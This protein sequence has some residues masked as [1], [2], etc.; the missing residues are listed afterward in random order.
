M[1]RRR[2]R[3][4]RQWSRAPRPRLV[5]PSPRGTLSPHPRGCCYL[6]SASAA[7]RPPA[8]SPPAAWPCL[9]AVSSS[10]A[11][12]PGALKRRGEGEDTQGTGSCARAEPTSADT[13]AWRPALKVTPY[14]LPPALS[15][16]RAVPAGDLD[17]PL[18]PGVAAGLSRSDD[19][20]LAP[21]EHRG[22]F[23]FQ[24]LQNGPSPDS[25]S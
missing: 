7:H 12:V 9:L 1:T 5:L 17:A 24:H 10:V 6:S 2:V 18:A 19:V 3:N 4:R 21:C 13:H 11:S 8:A 15:R 16:R 14:P 22:P 23:G 25:L 20:Q